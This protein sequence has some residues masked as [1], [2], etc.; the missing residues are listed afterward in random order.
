MDRMTRDANSAAEGIPYSVQ[1]SQA[2]LAEFACDERLWWADQH[3]LET[4]LREDM[5]TVVLFDQFM[6]FKSNGY[7]AGAIYR[8]VHCR[9]TPG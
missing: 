7:C 4:R 9:A 1:A 3:A 5:R 2:L 8:Q 6:L